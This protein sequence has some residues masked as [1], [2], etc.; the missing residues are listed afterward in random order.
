M[1]QVYELRKQLRNAKTR[2]EVYRIME[3]VDPE[4]ATEALPDR[5][6]KLRQLVGAPTRPSPF[7]RFFKRNS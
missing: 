3:G 1:G 6:N 7:D 2:E 5:V 4:V